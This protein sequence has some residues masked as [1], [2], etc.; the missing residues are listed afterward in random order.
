MPISHFVCRQESQFESRFGEASKVR[1]GLG[2]RVSRY[3]KH[4]ESRSFLVVGL[5]FVSDIF[6]VRHRRLKK[7]SLLGFALASL[8]GGWVAPARADVSREYDLKAVLLFNLTRF[9]EWPAAAFPDP[10][11]PMIIGILGQDPYGE[12]LDEVVRTESYGRHKIQVVRYRT[13]EAVR[14]CQILYVGSSEQPNLPRILRG[15]AGRPILSVGEFDGFA[16]AGGMVR[17][18]QNAEGKI[19]IRI[20]L[21]AV[22][23]AGLTV[24]GKL[25]RVAEIINPGGD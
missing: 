8:L 16:T 3:R 10:D 24:S 23:A 7:I 17:L 15:L 22:R 13:I 21:G 2:I 19:R 12:T 11:A 9:V 6:S 1:F 5:P 25:L 4:C 20:N 18:F 14:N